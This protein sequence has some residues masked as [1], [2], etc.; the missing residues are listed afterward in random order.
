MGKEK[1]LQSD[2]TIIE[3]F[4]FLIQHLNYN[5][6]K[7]YPIISKKK[8]VSELTVTESVTKAI[9]LIVAFFTVAF[10]FFKILFF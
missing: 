8:E 3:P 10:F 9:A 5:N 6:M 4:A 1:C 7:V 2:K